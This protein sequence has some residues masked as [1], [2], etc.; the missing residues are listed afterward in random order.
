MNNN[1]VI[2]S[3]SNEYQVLQML[4][5]AQHIDMCSPPLNEYP[6]VHNHIVSAFQVSSTYAILCQPKLEAPWTW[7]ELR[8]RDPE[9]DLR[10]PMKN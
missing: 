8:W 5:V 4:I 7:N 10:R 2:F 3:K 9:Q 6:I 1:E